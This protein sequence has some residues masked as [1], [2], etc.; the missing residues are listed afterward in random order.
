[1]KKSHLSGLITIENPKF[2]SGKYDIEPRIGESHNR[3]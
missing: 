2:I 1:M 3:T